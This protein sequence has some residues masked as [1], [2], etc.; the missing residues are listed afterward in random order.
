M[1]PYSSMF[2]REKEKDFFFLELLHFFRIHLGA[3]EEQAKRVIN[4][5]KGQNGTRYTGRE[6]KSL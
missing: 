4:N 1:S 6:H 2:E 3:N 5:A